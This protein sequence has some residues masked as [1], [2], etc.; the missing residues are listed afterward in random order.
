MHQMIL[1]FFKPSEGV[2][3]VDHIR[4][5]TWKAIVFLAFLYFLQMSAYVLSI[6]EYTFAPLMTAKGWKLISYS[7]LIF[8]IGTCV[9]M[10]GLSMAIWTAARCLDGNA[11]ISKTRSAVIWFMI[12]S[13]PLGFFWLFLFQA[14]KHHEELGK[15]SVL[16]G[17][18]SALGILT[19]VLFMLFS[20]YKSVSEINHFSFWK[21]FTTLAIAS[22]I[23]YAILFAMTI[24]T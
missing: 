1:V 23:C 9:V 24:I 14:Y 2:K 6:E 5:K 3:Y 10:H 17:A 12:G 13:A 18:I 22:G 20:L 7:L 16:V 4:N 11:S 8:F 21:T 15:L 19:T